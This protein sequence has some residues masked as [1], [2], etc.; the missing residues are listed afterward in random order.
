[1]IKDQN[2]KRLLFLTLVCFL[3]FLGLV[4]Y[5]S[6]QNTKISDVLESRDTLLDLN[7]RTKLWVIDEVRN[8]LLVKDTESYSKAK[9]LS[10]MDSYMKYEFYG[11]VYNPLRYI[12]AD[13]VSIVDAQYTLETPNYSIYYVLAEITREEEVRQINFL[14]FVSNNLIYDILIY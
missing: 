9:S 8:F 10:H 6:L 12:S 1:M 5:T 3:L 13:T 7:E 14:V 11:E 2:K 4:L